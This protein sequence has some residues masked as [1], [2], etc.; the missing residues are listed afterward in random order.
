MTKDQK[1]LAAVGAAILMYLVPYVWITGDKELHAPIVSGAFTLCAAALAAFVV[2]RQLRRQAENTDKANRQIEAMKLKKEVY[3][4]ILPSIKKASK[5][6]G[7]VS[8]YLRVFVSEVQTALYY[9]QNRH[10]IR[11]PVARF[12]KYNE[13]MGKMSTAAIKLITFTE[14][15]EI[16]E[17]KCEL[18]RVAVSDVLHDIGQARTEYQHH[19]MRTMPIENAEGV[20]YPWTALNLDVDGLAA[21]TEAFNDLLSTL[22]SYIHDI[23]IE[24]QI[25][26]LSDMFNKEVKRR[27][28]IDPKYKVIRLDRYDELKAY[29]ATTPSGIHNQKIQDDLR[30]AQGGT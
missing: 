18:F 22:Q 3:S 26:L 15:W 14:E 23:R 13:L 6:V 29:F 16:I 5:A 28:P 12:L 10:P 19:L 20:A 1:A 8:G 9:E 24:A 7:N 30:K 11:I 21:A 17:P 4:D 2:F 27:E 25:F